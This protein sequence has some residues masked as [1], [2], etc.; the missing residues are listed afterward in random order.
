MRGAYEP[1]AVLF[2]CLWLSYSTWDT[3]QRHLTEAAILGAILGASFLVAV[4]LLAMGL[5]FGGRWR[6]MPRGLS[7]PL[8][9]KLEMVGRRTNGRRVT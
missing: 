1:L 2:A 5:I 4:F 6:E 9:Q 8:V 3:A 7:W